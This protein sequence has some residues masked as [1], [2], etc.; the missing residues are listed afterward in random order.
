M[1]ETNIEPRTEGTEFEVVNRARQ[2]GILATTK[3]HSL[4]YSEGIII[5]RRDSIYCW[6]IQKLKEYNWGGK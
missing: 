3:A 2:K 1:E 6:T 5:N 4:L